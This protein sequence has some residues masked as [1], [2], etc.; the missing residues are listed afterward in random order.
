M[1]D[2]F[3]GHSYSFHEAN[4][5]EMSPG[6]EVEMARKRIVP[7]TKA[8][9]VAD[10]C[11]GS[12]DARPFRKASSVGMPSTFIKAYN[13]IWGLPKTWIWDWKFEYQN[14][15]FTHGNRSGSYAHVNIAR[16]N[17]KSTVSAHVHSS[18]GV[19]FLSSDYDLIWGMNVGCLINI[20]E[21][22]FA[23][24]KDYT[25]RPVIGCGVVLNNSTLPLFIPMNLK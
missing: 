24:A 5:N 2:V 10:I 16:D 6:Y 3:D 23:Y 13:D 11:I 25:Q 14:I 12:H 15:I 4:P 1:G 18:A 8:F 21:Y 19:H 20:K 17:R 7:W 22:A 9:P